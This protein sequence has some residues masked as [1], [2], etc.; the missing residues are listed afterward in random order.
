MEVNCKEIMFLVAT[1]KPMTYR[2]S[3]MIAHFTMERRTLN[4]NLP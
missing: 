4:V 3:L 1:T 2:G